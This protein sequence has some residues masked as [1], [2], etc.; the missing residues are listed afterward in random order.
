MSNLQA[1]FWDVDGTLA[2]TEMYGHRVAFNKAFEEVGL[3]WKWDLSLYGQ[4][5]LIAGGAKRIESYAS[6]MNQPLSVSDIT[7]IHASK[8]GHYLD[9]LSEGKLPCRT[10]VKR[11]VNELKS[12]DIKQWI[13]TTSSLKAVQPLVQTIFR[14]DDY[15]FT[16]L[17]TYEDVSKHKPHPDAYEKALHLSG[18]NASQVISIEDSVIGLAAAKAAGLTCLVTPAPWNKTLI[19]EFKQPVSI[20][21]HLGDPEKLSTVLRGPICPEGMVTPSYLQSLLLSTYHD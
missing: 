2:D 12:L 5:L 3:P 17:I 11:L 21:D 8:Q 18:F 6:Q 9:I 16:G 20:L 7:H 19:Q 15:P 14:Q 10:G 1:V 4:L 13:V